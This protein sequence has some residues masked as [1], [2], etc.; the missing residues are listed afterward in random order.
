M[1]RRTSSW[2]D[3]LP[4]AYRLAAPPQGDYSYVHLTSYQR[5]GNREPGD[6]QTTDQHAVTC[7]KCTGYLRRAAEKQGPDFA[8]R[9]ARGEVSVTVKC[10]RCRGYGAIQPRGMSAPT[11][12]PRCSGTG[13]VSL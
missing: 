4:P 5:C 9:W 8:A 10:P 2:T 7:P 6:T 1:T 12:C 11:Q 3:T 13:R